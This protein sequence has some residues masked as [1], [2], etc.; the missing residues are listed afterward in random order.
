MNDTRDNTGTNCQNHD[1]VGKV[2]LVLSNSNENLQRQCQICD[3]VLNSRQATAD[4][5]QS[6]CFPA[7]VKI[8]N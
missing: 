2:F 3:A 5:A 1:H 6:L 8:S 7:K 4:H